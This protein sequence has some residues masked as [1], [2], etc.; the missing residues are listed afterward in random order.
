MKT[1]IEITLHPDQSARAQIQA[2][3][4]NPQPHFCQYHA[5]ELLPF[6]WQN[7]LDRALNDRA[8]FSALF[9]A[10]FNRC[11]HCPH[12]EMENI[13]AINCA[14]QD[15]FERFGKHDAD[16]KPFPIDI[17]E[18]ELLPDQSPDAALGTWAEKMKCSGM[19][20]HG[21]ALALR[22]VVSLKPKELTLHFFFAS[23]PACALERMGLTPDEARASF[24]NFV[25]DP[26]LLEKYLRACQEY[27][28]KP[29]GVLLLLGSTGTGK[30]HL[31]TAVLR[32]RIVRGGHH[33]RF[34]K[35]RHLF[36]QYWQSIRPVSFDAEQPESPLKQCQQAPLLMLDELAMLPKHF[37][38][39]G[40]LLD[41]FEVRLGAYRPTIITSNFGRADL[42][43]AIGS[44]LFD[45]LR[46][47]SA[48]VLEFGFDSKRPQFNA[49]YLKHDPQWN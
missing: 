35:A 14:A 38:A 8:V 22:K 15:S 1:P 41:L 33:L 49:D 2:A 44:R 37:D 28:A 6:N 5:G 23:C 18:V 43:A 4:A 32:D 34:F 20:C 39:E 21:E 27:A 17:E 13:E 12:N 36:D 47:A 10:A 3:L 29:K 7:S 48:A 46:R 40:F 11:H 45:R 31:G 9:T 19:K 42:E 30:T 24:N 16:G 26:P 25:C